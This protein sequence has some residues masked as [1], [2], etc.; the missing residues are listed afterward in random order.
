VFTLIDLVSLHVRQMN[1]WRSSEMTD[2]ADVSG[3]TG[4]GDA[5]D[6]DGGQEGQELDGEVTEA[7]FC[8]P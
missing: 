2:I 4:A 1:N 6:D 8:H 3:R 7:F 5:S